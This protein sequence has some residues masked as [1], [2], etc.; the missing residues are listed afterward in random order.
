MSNIYVVTAGV[1]D[2]YRVVTA[3]SN[4]DV[5]EK[6]CSIC[7]L[8]AIVEEYPDVEMMDLDSPV[9][10]VTI[11]NATSTGGLTINIVEMMGESR[12][13]LL[14]GKYYKLNKVITQGKAGK[15]I[16]VQAPNEE[17]AYQKAKQLMKEK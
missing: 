14:L 7:G 12:I 16:Y 1:Q 2:D 15:S 17:M 5:A 11:E 9:Y 3:C 4:K 13:D 6:N 8:D 10:L